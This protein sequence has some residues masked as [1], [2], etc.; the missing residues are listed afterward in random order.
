MYLASYAG[1]LSGQH[2]ENVYQ[3]VKQGNADMIEALE[4]SI[5][6]ESEDR[7]R[8]KDAEYAAQADRRGEESAQGV[9]AAEDRGADA[10]TGSGE[11]DKRN[12]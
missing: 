11:N 1:G 5:R 4:A 2:L 12:L 8:Q 3:K 6:D 10:Q 7:R 9:D